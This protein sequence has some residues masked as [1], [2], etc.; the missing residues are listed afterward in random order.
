[1]LAGVD[2]GVVRRLITDAFQES[3]FERVG[4]GR[5]QARTE[6]LIW[7][8]DLDRGQSWSAWAVMVG[9]VVREWHADLAVPRHH[10]G[11]VMIE[12]AMLGEAVPPAAASS[13]FG[14]HLSYFTMIF[15][16]RHDLVSE[17]E[18]AEAFTFMAGDLAYLIQE[19]P[20]VSDLRAAVAAGR[21]TRG[22]VRPRLR[23][24]AQA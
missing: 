18:R 16:H 11:D 4:A 6:E 2:A 22:F 23:E 17:E 20:T 15:D 19:L 7:A 3:P 1:M 21:F 5:W 9:I 24:M 8:F 12:Y 13:R 14:D 10:D